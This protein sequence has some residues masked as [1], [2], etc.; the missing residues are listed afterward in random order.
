MRALIQ[1]VKEASVYIDGICQSSINKGLLI[2]LGVKQG[3]TKDCALNLAER[4]VH[5]RIFEDQYGKMNLSVN[6]VGGSVLVVSQ[7]TLYADTKRGHRPSFT[8]AAPPDIAE[9]LYN[10]FVEKLK[11]QIGDGRVKTGIFRAMMD[12]HLINDGPVTITLESK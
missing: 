9:I 11:T 1:R 7:F 4:C 10:E 8:D 12:I 3:D 2:F 5:L 6:D